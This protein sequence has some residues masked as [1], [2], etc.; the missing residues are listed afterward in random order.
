MKREDLIRQGRR[1]AAG[2]MPSPSSP[3]TT[4]ANGLTAALAD[5]P[6]MSKRHLRLLM[7]ALHAA[8][9]LGQL[10]GEDG[11]DGL[12]VLTPVPKASVGGSES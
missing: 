2:D 1:M 10:R 12:I 7:E 8:Y 3:R 4:Y 11:G 9:Q 5:M 6:G